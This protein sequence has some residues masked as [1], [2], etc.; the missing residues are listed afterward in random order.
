MPVLIRLPAA[1]AAFFALE[2]L[3]FLLQ[4]VLAVP[5]DLAWLTYPASLLMSLTVAVWLWRRLGMDEGGVLA[6]V[7]KWSLITG[8]VGFAGGF[9]GPIIFTPEANQGPLLGIFF[10]GPLGFIAGGV[11][12]LFRALWRD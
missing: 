8:A 12:G 6:T 4:I 3:L 7:A 5:E 11:A 2:G 9:F 1:L 10:T